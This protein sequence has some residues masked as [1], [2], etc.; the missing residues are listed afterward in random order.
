MLDI[1]VQTW[2]CRFALLMTLR[3]I[4]FILFAS[5]SCRLLRQ[6]KQWPISAERGPLSTAFGR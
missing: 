3:S 4:F 1:L 6:V 5:V 2:A